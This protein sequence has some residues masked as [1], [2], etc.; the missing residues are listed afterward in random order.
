MSTEPIERRLGGS[1]LVVPALGVGTNRWG[2][3]S[4][5]MAQLGE[6]YVAAVGSGTAFFD[7]A[8]VY[9]RGR[10]ERALG[11]CARHDPGPV[12]LATKFAPFPHRLSAGQFS[13]ALDASLA[14]LGRDSVDLY[15]LHFPY[16]LRSVGT[17]MKAMVSA[18]GD[19][20]IRAVGISNCGVARMRRAASVLAEHGLPLAANQ[21]QYSL[22]HR[23]PETNGVLDACRE[24]DVALVAYQP[25]GGAALID[26]APE[27]SGRRP[28][29]DVLGEIGAAHGFSACQVALAWMLR[30][31]EQII[32]I[33]GATK[34][35]HVRENAASM[36]LDLSDE[37]FGAIEACATSSIQRST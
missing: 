1:G 35:A 30:R 3:R 21:V 27:R 11:A 15:Y 10:S 14:R 19:G 28:L 24:L 9:M 16:S 25:L 7:T 23:D 31:D 2:T 33:P 6:A 29:L 26:G 34:A 13:R 17:W 18:V 4:A 12:V 5:D 22:I 32:P 37:E 36:A 20:R 8:E